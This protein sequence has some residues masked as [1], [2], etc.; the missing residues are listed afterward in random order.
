MEQD[1]MMEDNVRIRM[2][3]YVWLGHFTVENWQNTVNQL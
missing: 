3:K 2:Y 1:D